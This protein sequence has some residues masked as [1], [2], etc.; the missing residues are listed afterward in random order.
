MNFD[1]AIH[2]ADDRAPNLTWK[3]EIKLAELFKEIFELPVVLTNDANAAALGE[4]IYGGAKNM[5]DFIMITLGTGLGSGLVVNGKMVYGHDGFAGELGHVTV[6]INGR[7]CACGKKGCLET[8][9]SATGIERT[10]FELMATEIDESELRKYSFDE[11][12][13]KMISE[14][15]LKGDTLA[16]K[17]FDYTGKL[18]GLKLA[19]AVAHTSPEAIFLF[20]GLAAAKDLIFLPTIKYFEQFLL[21]IYRNKI[22]ILPSALQDKNIAVLGAAALYLSEEISQNL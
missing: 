5:K 4:M 15:A 7:Q 19:D 22:Q 12:D 8:Y 2:V 14:A 20:G 16:L 17:A 18:L 21:P 13:A 6:D 11:L 10:A 9:A 1:L 3:G